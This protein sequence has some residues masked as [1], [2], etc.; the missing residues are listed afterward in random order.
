[1]STV[2]VIMRGV[3]FSRGEIFNLY[4]DGVINLFGFL[5][6]N[7]IGFRTNRISK[8][9]AI[10][11]FFIKFPKMISLIENKTRTAKYMKEANF[12]LFLLQ[13]FISSLLMSFNN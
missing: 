6:V 2:S 7:S 10:I 13:Y 12:R 8:E 4:I 9:D 1:M 5:V 3:N 11:S